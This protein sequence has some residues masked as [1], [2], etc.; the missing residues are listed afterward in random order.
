VEDEEVSQNHLKPLHFQDIMRVVRRSSLQMKGKSP[1]EIMRAIL[2]ELEIEDIL[3]RTLTRG[4]LDGSEDGRH[5][6]IKGNPQ[7]KD[8]LYGWIGPAP[9]HQLVAKAPHNLT[10][11]DLYHARCSQCGKPTPVL[12]IQF[13]DEVWGP[14]SISLTLECGKPVL[15]GK[16]YIAYENLLRR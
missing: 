9:Y 7:V 10:T 1:D 14:S 6:E 11:K 16:E 13:E 2:K 12:V 3:I 15:K 8:L 5:Y 4:F